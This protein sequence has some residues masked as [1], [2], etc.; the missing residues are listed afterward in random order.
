MSFQCTSRAVQG[1]GPL[2]IG[3][4]VQVRWRSAVVTAGLRYHANSVPPMTRYAS[5]L[6]GLADLSQVDDADLVPYLS[7]I[8]ASGAVPFLRHRGQSALELPGSGP[9]L[10]EG[11]RILPAELYDRQ[12]FRI[13]FL[14][15][16]RYGIN[17]LYEF[18]TE[19]PADVSAP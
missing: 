6:G 7:A 8:G 1:P 17:F 19:K 3:A 10:P 11:A 16:K 18:C 13:E 5:P 15:R 12:C 9:P 2:D 4:G 14:Y